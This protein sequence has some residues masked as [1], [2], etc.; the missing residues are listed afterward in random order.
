MAAGRAI[1]PINRNWRYRPAK[2]EGAELL[3]FDDA[4]FER[5]AVP[6]TN[7][8]LPWHNFDDKDY[9][10]VSTYRRRFT[11]PAEA[12][13]K[14]V[15]VDFEGV[16]TATTVWINGVRLGE[17]KGGFTPFSFELT[18]HVRPGSENV[19]LLQVDSTERTD[20]PPS[21]TRSTT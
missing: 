7:V 8:V 1:L 14:R 15:F 4:Q 3:S 20:I 12:A 6:H 11:L 13:G 19:L 9:E 2:V 5:V 18:S 16:M 17:Y 10:L 21:A